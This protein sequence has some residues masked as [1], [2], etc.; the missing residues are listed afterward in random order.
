MQ[1][2]LD[3]QSNL[4]IE[5]ENHRP[6]Y[7]YLPGDFVSQVYPEK[8]DRRVINRELIPRQ[9]IEYEQY[10]VCTICK[11]PCAGTCHSY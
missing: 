1:S 2:N 10:L 7:K 8:V 5:D 9:I 11:R 4:M 6:E 3:I